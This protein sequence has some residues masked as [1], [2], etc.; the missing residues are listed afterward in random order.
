MEAIAKRKDA[1]SG[2]IRD[3]TIRLTQ[4]LHHRMKVKAA[5]EKVDLYELAEEILE[6]G[7]K[8]LP[9][10]RRTARSRRPS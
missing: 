8:R 2:V 3:K 7:M 9:E 1:G 5:E 4:D 10:I 6:W